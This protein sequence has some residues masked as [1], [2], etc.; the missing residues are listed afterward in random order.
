MDAVGAVGLEWQFV[1][2]GDFS[3]NA[4]ETEMLMRDVNNGALV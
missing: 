4:G 2:V 3:G 1:G